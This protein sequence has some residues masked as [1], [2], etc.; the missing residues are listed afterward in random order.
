MRLSVLRPR[1]SAPAATALAIAL[2]LLVDR[3]ALGLV[4]LVAVLILL[5]LQVWVYGRY[6]KA[7]RADDPAARGWALDTLGAGAPLLIGYA[8]VVAGA[9]RSLA[10]WP[11]QGSRVWPLLALCCVTLLYQLALLG[12][13]LARRRLP[14]RRWTWRLLTMAAGVA[15]AAA[16]GVL[17]A[18]R[19]MS[20]L[21]ARYEPLLE[22]LVDSPRPCEEYERYLQAYTGDSNHRPRSLH[23]DSGRSVLTFAGGSADMDGSTIV[24]DS[25]EAAPSIFHNDDHRSRQQLEALQGSLKRCAPPVPAAATR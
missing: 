10:A 18:S 15:L 5:P 11:S 12:H 13:W 17:A 8:S 14:L 7:A 19:A 4:L 22:S 23:F 6:R 1:F 24:L 2:S 20:G 9:W 3:T 21:A 25:N 16:V